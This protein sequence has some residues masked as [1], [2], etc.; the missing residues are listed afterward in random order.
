[1]ALSGAESWAAL[2]SLLLRTCQ[3]RDAGLPPDAPPLVRVLLDGV[4]WE[5]AAVDDWGALFLLACVCR[6]LRDLRR[7]PQA[8]FAITREMHAVWARARQEDLVGKMYYNRQAWAERFYL[9]EWLYAYE[10]RRYLS[11]LLPPLA[12]AELEGV[13]P[14]RPPGRRASA[15]LVWRDAYCQRN[16]YALTPRPGP[17]ALL[18]R[19]LRFYPGG[20]DEMLRE[21]ARDAE[22][23]ARRRRYEA[24]QSRCCCVC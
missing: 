15:Y 4:F 9:L 24:E 1:M 10:S 21:R 14:R 3:Y 18:L 11:G 6:A 20:V 8:W 16:M 7:H 2:R 17:L 19:V 22:F 12:M 23:L 5:H 13:I